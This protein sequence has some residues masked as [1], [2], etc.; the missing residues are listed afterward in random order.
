MGQ[1]GHARKQLYRRPSPQRGRAT[2]ERVA[3]GLSWLVLP[4]RRRRLRVPGWQQHRAGAR[5]LP[6]AST[7]E[8]EKR[9]CFVLIP[10]FLSRYM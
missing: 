2:A 8:A 1:G 9:V 6:G 5:V 3:A 10:L 7:G 4:W